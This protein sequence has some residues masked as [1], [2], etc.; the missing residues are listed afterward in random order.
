MS[1]L[2]DIARRG[3]AL[4]W[5]T[6]QERS[7]LSHIADCKTERLG[8]NVLSC[9]C[10]H[11]EVHYNSCRDR[12][13]PLCQG[14]A[15]ARWV[16]AR[17]GELLPCGYFHVVFTVP[18]ELHYLALSNRH[19][20]Y[21]A[22]FLSVHE[23]LKDVCAN[24]AN[25][26]ARVG[27][28]SILHTW[29]QKLAF[30]P[31][32]HCIVPTGGISS[33]F[34]RWIA[35]NPTYLVSVK[36]LSAVF[37]GKLLSRLEQSIGRHDLCGDESALRDAVCAAARKDFVVYAKPPF[38]G[39]G[40]VVK[41]LG[42]Y[43]HRVGISEPRIVCVTQERV[44]FSWIDR[45][46]GHARRVMSLSCDEFIRKFTLH[47]LP[48]G[49]RKIRYFGFMG[50]RDRTASLVRVRALIA[51]S[52]DS[53]PNRPET[54][55]FPAHGS[56]MEAP[57]VEPCAVS[58]CPRCG[59]PLSIHHPIGVSSSGSHWLTSRLAFLREVHGPEPNRAVF[60]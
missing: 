19:A 37:R 1:A 16:R 56:A 20:F 8:G 24:P 12:H 49:L 14:A 2:G 50:N 32:I 29:N 60:A 48:K 15:C 18:H 59:L 6:G 26:G 45:A 3:M 57:R 4:S 22:L 54:D 43:T 10:G 17:L 40:Q 39:P 33:D 53:L 23:T 36:R 31:H 47:I 13:C 52:S 35:G 42:R 30:H 28:M 38:G 5:L 44:S 11:R 27:G 7:V 25:L 46:A 21:R 55:E 34:S 58:R 9:E 41:Y 51:S